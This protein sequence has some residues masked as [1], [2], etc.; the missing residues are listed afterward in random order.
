MSL[1]V[2]EHTITLTVTDDRG[3]SAT[4]EVLV[5]VNAANKVPVAKAGVDQTLSG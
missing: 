2:G 4:D 1:T 3:D 5:T